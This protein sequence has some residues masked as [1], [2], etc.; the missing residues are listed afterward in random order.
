MSSDRARE[1][2]MRRKAERQGITLSK[3]KA[4]DPRALDYG[5]TIDDPHDG[6]HGTALT[7][8]EVEAYLTWRQIP[9]P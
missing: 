1:V 3:S 5:W 9:E 6:W 4:R 8:D 7:L 2:R